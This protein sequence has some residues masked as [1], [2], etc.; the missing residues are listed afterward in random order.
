[1]EMQAEA[2]HRKREEILQSEGGNTFI[3]SKPRRTCSTEAE[4]HT[5]STKTVKTKEANNFSK[6]EVEM[7]D[8]MDTLQHAI[9]IGRDGQDLYNLAEGNQHTEH[10]QRNGSSHHKE[11]FN[12]KSLQQKVSMNEA[13]H[14]AD[15]RPVH[16]K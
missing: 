1:M 12:V 11:D 7:V 9:S 5:R 4:A 13:Y 16:F 2:E 3:T 14:R 15:H 8:V 10:G 6:S